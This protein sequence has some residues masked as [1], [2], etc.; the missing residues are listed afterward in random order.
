MKNS[1][2]QRLG[3]YCVSVFLLA[4]GT[5]PSPVEAQSGLNDATFN[6]PDKIDGQGAN[7]PVEVSAKQNTKLLIAGNFTSYNGSTANKLARLEQDGAIDKTFNSGAGPNGKIRS[8][9]TLSNNKI[10]VAGNFNTYNNYIKHGLARLFPDGSPDQSFTFGY[11]PNRGIHKLALQ[12]DKILVVGAFK[13]PNWYG[14][15]SLIRL[16]SNGDVDASFHPQLGKLRDIQQIVVQPD[17][18]ILLAGTVQIGSSTHYC[19]VIR[20]DKD[21]STDPA[22]NLYT[23]SYGD[24]HQYVGALALESNGNILFANNVWVEDAVYEGYLRRLNSSGNEIAYSKTFWTNA[25]LIQNDGKIIVTGFKQL[26]RDAEWYVTKRAIVRLNADLSVDASFNFDDEKRYANRFPL[27][28]QILTSTLQADNKIIIGGEFSETSGYVTNNIA[29]IHTNGS[30]DDSFNQHKGCSGTILAS[31]VLKN[32]KTIVGGR[33]NKYNNVY[34]PNIARLNKNGQPDATFQPGRGTNG[35]IYTIAIQSNNKILIGGD[36]TTYDG[37]TCSNM[38]RLNA[39]G[40]FDPGFSVAADNVVRKIKLDNAGKIFISGDFKNINGVP[41]NG[42]ARL[43]ANG[44]NDDTFQFV[45][46]NDYDQDIYDFTL[47]SAGKLY[48]ALNSKTNRFRPVRAVLLRL[49]N[50]GTIDNTFNTPE[51]AEIHAVGLKNNKP[52][53]GGSLPY[54]GSYSGFVAQ[55]NTNG[56]LDSAFQYNTLKDLLNAPVR[57]ITILSNDKLIIAGDFSKTINSTPDHI[58]LLNKNGS[59]NK[60]FIGS[61]NGSVYTASVTSDEK[62]FIGGAFSQ[63]TNLVRN[64]AARIDIEI[65]GNAPEASPSAIMTSAE[66]KDLILYPNPAQSAIHAGHLKPGS[67]IKIFNTVGQELYSQT[68][69]NEEATID[70]SG[71]SNGVYLF[72]SEQNGNRSFSKFIVNKQ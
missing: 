36:F 38:V 49:S 40:S 17:G 1:I 12:D 72:V 6:K 11:G 57:T 20:L 23:V 24:Y 56:T 55:L 22:F 7:G 21:G 53:I 68:L 35:K 42:I 61:A 48:V 52:V 70:L 43:K 46:D 58:T 63:Y 39:D 44:T 26:D 10:L 27:K 33:F 67:T 19:G 34:T 45:N 18:K 14:P 50:N 66:N 54:W 29:R 5:F 51:F 4:T 47:P 65:G 15:D 28:S 16:N 71:F 9:L 59:I 64:G 30:F 41:A 13:Y 62:L 32:G 37:H 8:I 25:Y 31:A 2:S 69:S 60:N 3:A